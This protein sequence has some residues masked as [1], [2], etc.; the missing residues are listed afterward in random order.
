MRKL[1]DST[2]RVLQYTCGG[3]LIDS[4]ISLIAKTF[5]PCITLCSLFLGFFSLHITSYK[6]SLWVHFLSEL[7]I[8]FVLNYVKG[9]RLHIIYSS[10]ASC[11]RISTKENA[12]LYINYIS[13]KKDFIH[14][15]TICGFKKREC[16]INAH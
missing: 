15:K 2:P 3:A 14:Y 4:Q 9:L 12:I 6:F 13:I 5:A 1:I 11:G 10:K 16:Y 8:D 7:K